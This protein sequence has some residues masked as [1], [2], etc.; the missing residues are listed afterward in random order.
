VR[1]SGGRERT[2][3]TAPGGLGLQDIGPDGRALVVQSTFRIGIRARLPGDVQDRELSW[4]DWSLLRDIS[5]D[6][7][8]ILFEETG[9]GAGRQY[10]IYVRPTDGGPA[11]RLGD[12]SGLALSPDGQFVLTRSGPGKLGLL[13]TG[14]GPMRPVDS[15][16]L[17]P[18]GAMFLPD[19]KRVIL[20][21]QEPNAGLRLFVL[22]LDGG[23]AR[24]LT[25]EGIPLRTGAP[26]PDGRAVLAMGPDTR[27]YLYPVDGGEPQPFTG[28]GPGDW[29]IRWSADGRSLYSYPR[30]GPP[31]VIRRLD[32]ATGR[33][34]V[35]HEAVPADRAGFLGI[36]APQITPD[37]RAIA[38]SYA[39]GLATLYA[40]EG[41]R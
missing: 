39:E 38:Y 24:P 27:L 7:R 5:A 4:L 33:Q 16:T 18:V 1:A 19:G 17:D 29:P 11:I 32:V 21:A 28:L 25:P 36:F 15:G 30:G 37:G 23:G 35:V 2:I 6:G 20:R 10:G 41:L 14:A 13:P 22:P 34:E 9:E 3:A 26:T 12:G 31:W 40:V 8:R